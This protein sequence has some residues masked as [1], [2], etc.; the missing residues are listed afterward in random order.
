LQA[1]G[2]LGNLIGLLAKQVILLQ[3]LLILEFQGFNL[4]LGGLQFSRQFPIDGYGY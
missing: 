3:E 1:A 2:G 4:G